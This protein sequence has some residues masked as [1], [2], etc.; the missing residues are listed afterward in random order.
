VKLQYLGDSKDSFKWDYLDALTVGLGSSTL[1]VAWMMTADD[2]TSEGASAPERYP[3]RSGVVDL[4]R[5]LRESRN[6][7]RLE[8]LPTISGGGYRVEMDS[9]GGHFLH[10]ERDRYFGSLTVGSGQVLF[11]DPDNGFEPET[12]CSEKHVQYREIQALLQRTPPD[13]V[14]TIFQHHRRKHFPDDFARIRE[15]LDGGHSTALY[16]HSLMFVTLAATESVIDRVRRV[17]AEYARDRPV[18]VVA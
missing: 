9:V 2:G 4:C 12:R 16:W 15:R 14:I 6:P 17:N 11:L 3:A 13:S 18:S 7:Q 5:V 10:H 8:A 1:R